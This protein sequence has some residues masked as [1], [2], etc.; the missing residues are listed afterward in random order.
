MDLFF[1]PFCGVLRIVFQMYGW[2][3]LTGIVLKWLVISQVVNAYHPFVHK[4]R[5]F[6]FQMTDPVLRRLR[7][8]LPFVR[9]V[10]LAPFIVLMVVYFLQILAERAIN[11]WSL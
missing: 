7:R 8:S 9:G 1:V 10:D 4:L 11:F 3:L 2:I 5:D 6:C